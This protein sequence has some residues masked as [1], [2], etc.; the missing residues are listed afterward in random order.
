V[1]RRIRRGLAL[2]CLGLLA[3]SAFVVGQEPILA[4]SLEPS[5][6]AV[7]QGGEAVAILRVENGSVYPGEDIEPVLEVEG[8][9][10]VAEPEAIEELAPFGASTIALHLSA[11][12]ELPLGP[13]SRAL[14]VLYTYCIGELCYQ[15]SE[16]IPFTVTVEP[17]SETPVEV[18]VA[19]PVEPAR[20]F[21]YR[22]GGLGLGV[23][24]LAAAV[25]LRR[26]FSV[27]WPLYAVLILFVLGGLAYG[28]VLNQ[29]EQAQG[30][31]AVLCTSCVGIEAAQRGEPELTPAGIAAIE[32]IEEEIELLV[33]HAAWCH[34]CPYAEAMV[35]EVA[36]HNPRIRY[37]SVDVGEEPELAERSGVIR[38]GRTVVPAV[39]RVD[40]GEI[41]FGAEELETRLIDLLEG[42]P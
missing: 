32:G 38:S 9:T 17:P 30:I 33:F 24:L 20:P 18:P 26:A 5:E 6:I 10:L 2:V 34:A 41:V 31:G 29:H 22:L 15:I 16:E 19:L 23:L 42:E 1:I 8:L 37:R 3:A 4:F 27:R 21:W 40:T 11:S 28:V 36:R 14:G 13:S 35:E 39:L 12:A 7:P 25:A